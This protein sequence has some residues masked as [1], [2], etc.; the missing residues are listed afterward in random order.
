MMGQARG[1]RREASR[2][3]VWGF[4]SLPKI[5]SLDVPNWFRETYEP[6]FLSHF[7]GLSLTYLQL[8]VLEFGAFVSAVVSI[9]R[10]EFWTKN[11]LFL[12]LTLILS[13]L[14]FF[15]LGFGLNL[16]GNNDGVARSFVYFGVTLVAAMYVELQARFS[17]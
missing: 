13:L 9:M 5:T 12:K 6:T 3:L 16:A 8:V 2:C 1:V 15:V 7:P 14:N 4:A 17:E 11:Y 10:L